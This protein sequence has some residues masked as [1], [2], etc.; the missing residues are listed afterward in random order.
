MRPRIEHAT[1]DIRKSGGKVL[2]WHCAESRSTGL[3]EIQ[4]IV[5]RKSAQHLYFRKVIW[6]GWKAATCDCDLDILNR[7]SYLLPRSFL[8]R[9]STR[10]GT[11]AAACHLLWG[12]ADP[13]IFQTQTKVFSV[14]T[15]RHNKNLSVTRYH[16]INISKRR[17][18]RFLLFYT[19]ANNS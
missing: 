1:D 12:N 3:Q 18:K 4:R 14:I 7:P 11:P 17:K 2:D 5:L 8:P 10:Q 13:I 6:E 15:W 9:Q 16:Y 19:Y